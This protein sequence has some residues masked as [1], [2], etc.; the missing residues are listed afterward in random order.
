MTPTPLRPDAHTLTPA[1]S[2]GTLPAMFGQAAA[3]YVL[4]ELAGKPF[5]CGS[6]LP[7]RSPALAAAR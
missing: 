4:C 3:S 1:P 6:L 7:T 2:P 5:R